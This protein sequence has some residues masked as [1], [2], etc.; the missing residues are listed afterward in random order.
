[1]GQAR[2]SAG[3]KARKGSGPGGV[4]PPRPER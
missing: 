3:G 4:A 2:G 1:L